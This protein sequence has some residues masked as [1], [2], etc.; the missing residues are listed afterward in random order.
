MKDEHL[1]PG[2]GTIDW[3]ATANALKELATPPATVLEIG[4]NLN[5]AHNTLAT[6]ISAA[7]AKFE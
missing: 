5:D 6:K 3:P 2:D 4:Y 7:F 1:W